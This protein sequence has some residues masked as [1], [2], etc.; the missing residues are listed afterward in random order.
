MSNPSDEKRI[1]AHLLEEAGL[2]AAVAGSPADSDLEDAF[3]SELEAITQELPPEE[4]GGTRIIIKGRFFSLG[5]AGWKLLT[6]VASL[7]IST[8][9]PTGVTKAVALKEALDL[10]KEL[11]PLA[12][13]LDPGKV[14]VCGAIAAV[15]AERKRQGV[16]RGAT[17][18]DIRRHFS[19]RGQMPPP[20]LSDILSSLE[21]DEVI[22]AT[23]DEG[24]GPF[25]S[26]RF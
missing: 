12:R 16:R 6:S 25:Y 15:A 1:V 11:R 23:Y 24:S 5:N 19:D 4:V 8:L 20:K 2:P 22:K 10:F 21:G 3:L 17:E 13:K 9:D 26:I 14:L 18:E 7:A